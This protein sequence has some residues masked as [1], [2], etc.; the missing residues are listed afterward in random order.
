MAN[1]ND[2]KTFGESLVPIVRDLVQKVVNNQQKPDTRAEDA[3]IAN[4]S[5]EQRAAA[6]V[7][8]RTSL[9]EILIQ[10]A[11]SQISLSD[12]QVLTIQTQRNAL[13]NA[14]GMLAEQAAFAPI[15]TLLQPPEIA[16]ISTD[17][18]RARQGIQQRQAAKD[19]L[20][21][22]VTVAIVAAKIAAK[23]V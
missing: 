7:S 9:T 16:A 13:R 22:V 11:T 21:T 12:T 2:L 8:M 19:I 1:L 14:F 4:L 5:L 17:L 18:D 10:A 23:V 15:A 6:I 3:A 20:D